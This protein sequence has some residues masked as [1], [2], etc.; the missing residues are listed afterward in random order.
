M[1]TLVGL[2]LGLV[3]TTYYGT[4]GRVHL[5]ADVGQYARTLRTA[6]EQAILT[7]KTYEVFIE[8]YDGYYTVME[9]PE[10][11]E[12]GAEP[13]EPLVERQSLDLSWID[14]VEYEDGSRQYS[15][16]MT[17]RATPRGWEQA[18]LFRIVDKD[19][20]WR[21]VRCDRF[22]AHVAVS[23]HPLELLAAQD[24]VSMSSPL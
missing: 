4:I 22:T 19:N 13:A 3:G 11:E 20:R 10:E 14:E 17:L 1:L 9:A 16:D 15:Q 7:G 8:I 12:A 23:R 6:A 2:L 21:Y 18:V 24:E 5:D